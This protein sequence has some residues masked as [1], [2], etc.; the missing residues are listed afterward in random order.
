MLEEFI[1][2]RLV[3]SWHFVSL[4]RDVSLICSKFKRNSFRLGLGMSCT[5]HE[6]SFTKWWSL[7]LRLI[8]RDK[9]RSLFCRVQHTRQTLSFLSYAR[10]FSVNLIILQL[11][12]LFNN[13]L[14]SI[15]G[16]HCTFI[17]FQCSFQVDKSSRSLANFR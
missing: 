13:L 17:S 16:N 9:R 14:L 12:V 6:E 15:Y 4:K 8:L 5:S 7:I 1:G 10:S 3:Y 11:V 2:G